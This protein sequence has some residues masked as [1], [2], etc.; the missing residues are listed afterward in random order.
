MKAVDAG[1]FTAL[2]ADMGTASGSLGDLGATGVYRIVAPQTAS[3]PFVL[4]N[5][6]TGTSN[7]TMADV[8]YRSLLYQVKAIG[9]GH[10]GSVVAEMDARLDTVLNDQ[11]LTLSGWTCKRI[12]RESDVEYI[13]NDEGILYHHIGGLY[14]IDV[15][16]T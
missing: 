7:W 14:R 15:E 3:L 1:M 11:P 9:S 6:Q 13:E 4:F 10:S 16:P 5:E 2:N 12:R 8:G